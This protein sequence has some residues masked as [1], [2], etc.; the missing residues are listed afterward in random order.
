M[1]LHYLIPDWWELLGEYT[2]VCCQY[3]DISHNL[4]I[5]YSVMKFNSD[6]RMAKSVVR[7]GCLDRQSDVIESKSFHVMSPAITSCG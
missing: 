6:L 4:M 2:V 3:E 7:A 5:L 1:D